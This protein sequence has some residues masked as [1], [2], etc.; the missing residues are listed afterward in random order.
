[1]GGEQELAGRRVLITGAAR[2]IGALL[3]RRLHERGATLALL[4]LEP[5]QLA[6]VAAQCGGAPWYE[7]DVSQR[8]QVNEAVA[9][10]VRQ[11]GG[12][13]VVQRRGQRSGW[14]TRCGSS[15]VRRERASESPTT[16]SSTP[17]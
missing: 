17:T 13:D 15:C 4:G 16:P 12:L 7:C 3:A 9:D 5:E 8:D 14:A 2:G 11:L 10:A 6:A 1:M